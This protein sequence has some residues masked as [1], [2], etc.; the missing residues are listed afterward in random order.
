MNNVME[1]TQNGMFIPIEKKINLS[2]KEAAIY[3]GIGETR[4][5][6]MLS[7]RACPFRLMVGNKHL[8]KRQEFEKFLANVHYL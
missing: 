6:S 1:D 2:I 7:E 5:R 4:I 8:V 3:S